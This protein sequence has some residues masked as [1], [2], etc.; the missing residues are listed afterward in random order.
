MRLV[1][2]NDEKQAF[3]LQHG[4]PVYKYARSLK[5]ALQMDDDNDN[6]GDENSMDTRRDPAPDPA[7][8]AT[9]SVEFIDS[10]VSVEAKRTHLELVEQF[11]ELA[12]RNGMSPDERLD[13]EAEATTL[14]W[15]RLSKQVKDEQEQRAANA[16]VQQQQEKQQAPMSLEERLA[17]LKQT[18]LQ[19]WEQ[20]FMREKLTTLTDCLMVM[21]V[22]N[23]LDIPR[24]VGVSAKASR[25]LFQTMSLRAIAG[26]LGVED[27]DAFK[28]ENFDK[29]KKE[30]QMFSP[31]YIDGDLEDDS[32]DEEART[33][34][35]AK[36]E[37]EKDIAMDAAM[38]EQAKKESNP[39][40]NAI[41]GGGG[42]DN[43]NDEDNDEDAVD[44]MV[45]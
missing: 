25:P 17:S 21:M 32:D 29:I 41:G 4:S 37:R 1:P 39:G 9:D 16:G 36:L 11:C 2:I 42:D 7:V 5:D 45:E 26:E 3:A 31:I 44:S 30:H 10:P 23:E 12:L 20:T 28:K 8:A 34:A 13:P 24:L 40:F 14:Y 22:A 35:K 19:E 18:P 38:A 43:D 27:Y 6:D 15:E 33:V